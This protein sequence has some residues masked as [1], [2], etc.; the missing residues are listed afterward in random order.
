MNS[1]LTGYKTKAG[2]VLEFLYNGEMSAEVRFYAV[3]FIDGFYL[4]TFY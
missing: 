1:K 2:D 3:D 4:L